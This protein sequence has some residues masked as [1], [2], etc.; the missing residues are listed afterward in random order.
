MHT[1]DW[2]HTAQGSALYYLLLFPGLAVALM[3][4]MWW[5]WWKLEFVYMAPPMF[6]LSL[7]LSVGV[8]HS[9]PHRPSNDEHTLLKAPSLSAHFVALSRSLCCAPVSCWVSSSTLLSSVSPHQLLKVGKQIQLFT[10]SVNGKCIYT[11]KNV[12]YRQNWFAQLYDPAWPT[13]RLHV[14]N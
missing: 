1:H 13:N 12:K 9:C 5:E 7:P 14:L 6:P 3:L 10:P 8:Q 4:S 11:G 2:L